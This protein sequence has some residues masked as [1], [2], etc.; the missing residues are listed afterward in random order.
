M[1][2][3][4]ETSVKLK[5]N[6]RDAFHTCVVHSVW[7]AMGYACTL[8]RHAPLVTPLQARP[9]SSLETWCTFHAKPGC[10]V[11]FESALGG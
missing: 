5:F 6:Y 3:Y 7:G 8:T 2:R 9:S 11:I 10:E 1:H 4:K